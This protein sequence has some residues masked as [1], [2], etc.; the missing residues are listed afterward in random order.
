MTIP[1]ISYYGALLISSERLQTSTDSQ[2]Q[3]ICAPMPSWVPGIHQ[4]WR[5]TVPEDSGPQGGNPYAQLDNDSMHTHIHVLN[6]D[7]SS[8]TKHYNNRVKESRGIPRV[9]IVVAAARKLMEGNLHDAGR[10]EERP[11]RLDG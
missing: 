9:A 11:F 7:L 1:G 4:I 5:R 8:I 6:C 2:T 3:S 10:K